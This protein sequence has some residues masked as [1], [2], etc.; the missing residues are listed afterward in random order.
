MDK[1]QLVDAFSNIVHCIFCLFVAHYSFFAIDSILNKTKLVLK[2]KY[3]YQSN[4]KINLSKSILEFLLLLMMQLIK[5]ILSDK[6][7]DITFV[8]QELG[9]I[10]IHSNLSE[11]LS[12]TL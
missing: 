4:E 11:Y 12:V 10:H 5:D 6:A 9:I 1:L 3:I 7:K 2:L 8:L